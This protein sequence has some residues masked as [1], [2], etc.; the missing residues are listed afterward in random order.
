VYHTHNSRRSEPGFPDLTV[1]GAH[2]V[3]FRELKSERGRVTADQRRWLDALA[4]AGADVVV[5]R[6]CD[7]PQRIHAEL[8]SIR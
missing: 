7:W 2:G 4:A 8:E 1:V 6:P 3:L 5:W